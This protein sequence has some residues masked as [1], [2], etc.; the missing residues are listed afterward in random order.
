[1]ASG[2]VPVFCTT[3]PVPSGGVRPHREP[4]DVDRY[5]ARAL[6]IMTEHGVAVNDLNAFATSRLIEIQ[7]PVNVHF[8]KAGSAALGDA[9]ASRIRAIL[10]RRN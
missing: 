4:T 8:T 1:M 9:V 6:E 5:N 10:K 2:A 7:I 3:T